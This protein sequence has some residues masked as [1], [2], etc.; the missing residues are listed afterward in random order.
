MKPERSRRG[1][2]RHLL[3]GALLGALATLA[4]MSYYIASHGLNLQNEEQRAA[5]R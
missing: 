4:G 3:L 2:A 1:V 5:Q